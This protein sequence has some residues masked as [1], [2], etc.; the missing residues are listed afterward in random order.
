MIT[1]ALKRKEVELGFV[2]IPAKNRADLMGDLSAPF[3]TKLNDLPAKVDK[4]GRLWS[5][6]LKQ[7]YPVDTQVIIIRNN[8]GFQIA[9]I[10][11]KQE[12]AALEITKPTETVSPSIILPENGVSC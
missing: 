10:E 2:S 5:G 6:Y 7:R 3:N 4:Y 12:T 1:K 8:G 9:A 11:Q